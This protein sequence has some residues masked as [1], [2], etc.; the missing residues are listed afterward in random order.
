MEM[1]GTGAAGTGM[2]GTASE[3]MD[4]GMG[5]GSDV[6][7]IGDSWMNLVVAGIEQS[8]DRASGQMYRHH[9]FPGTLMLNEQIPMQ[10]EAAVAANPDIKT[11]VMTGGGNDILTSP[12]AD[13][14]CDSLVDD[15]SARIEELMMDMAEDGVLDV[16]LISYTYPADVTKHASLDRSIMLSGENCTPE[17]TPRCHFLDSTELD[18][19]LLPDGIHPDVASYELLGQTVWEL[20]VEEGVRR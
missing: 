7:T 17:M 15:I 16:V 4:Q 11:V 8:L 14:G 9:A 13:D 5:D 1:A 6:V 19:T 20:M 18:I 3:P 10:Y 12:C 2:A